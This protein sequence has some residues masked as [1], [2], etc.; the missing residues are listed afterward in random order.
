VSLSGH[1]TLIDQDAKSAFV[2]DGAG[3]DVITVKASDKDG[4]Y[5]F[6][7]SDG[8]VIADGF[9]K[10]RDWNVW[11]TGAAGK[12]VLG[13]LRN[14]D[15]R[16]LLPY[17]NVAQFGAF[18]R[19]TS[20]G[21]LYETPTV[22]N[23]TFGVNFPAPTAATNTID[24]LKKADLAAKYSDKNFTWMVLA[25]LDMVTPNNVVFGGASYTGYKDL[26]LTGLAKGE[27]DN[28]NYSLAGGVQYTGIDKLTLNVEGSYQTK[29]GY[30]DVWGQAAYAVTDAISAKVGAYYG[31]F[32]GDPTATPVILDAVDYDFY[33][34]LG[35]DLGNGLS[36]EASLGY[37]SAF[38][39]AAKLYYGVSF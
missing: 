4:K 33:G 18:D 24:V 13:N 22:K 29:M 14:S 7:L 27:F 12:V 36:A 21:V 17:W 16:M 6:S 28:A 32:E 1:V 30:Y 34:A 26:V 8:D 11:Y 31:F 38:H 39:A 15:F 5:G 2:R 20:Y 37:N 9:S 35:Y 3:Y 19:I 25:N 23:L 10:I